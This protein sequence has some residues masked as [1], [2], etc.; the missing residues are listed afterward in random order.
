MPDDY[1]NGMYPLNFQFSTRYLNAFA[2]NY[3]DGNFTTEAAFSVNVSS[4]D[5]AKPENLGLVSSTS[6][7]TW[8]YDAAAW[9]YWYTYSLPARSVVDKNDGEEENKIH[10]VY[11]QD[12]TSS[13]S[14]ITNLT[15]LGV[16]YRIQYFSYKEGSTTKNVNY[17][18]CARK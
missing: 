18:T 13:F 14:S 16:F 17:V 3:A 8:N 5:P 7:N 9:N 1:P 15:E 10:T 4:T 11:L 12:V 6:T 2:T